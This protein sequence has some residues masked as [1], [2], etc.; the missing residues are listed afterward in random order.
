MCGGTSSS[1]TGGNSQK[2]PSGWGGTGWGSM[3]GMF[4]YSGKNPAQSLRDSNNAGIAN[5]SIQKTTAAPAASTTQTKTT[6][7]APTQQ[8]T[9]GSKTGAVA[10][11]SGARMTSV[12][13]PTGIDATQETEEAFG[14]GTIST[15]EGYGWDFAKGQPTGGIPSWSPNRQEGA[16]RDAAAKAIGQPYDRTV[17]PSRATDMLSKGKGTL[18]T[19]TEG[20]KKGNYQYDEEGTPAVDKLGMTIDVASPFAN[21]ARG[22]IL[23][24]FY[25]GVKAI[26]TLRDHNALKQAGVF[27]TPTTTKTATNT[28]TSTA[29]RTVPSR[30]SATGFNPVA[31]MMGG[32]D[33]NGRKLLVSRSTPAATTTVTESKRDTVA[34]RP[35]PPRG[36]SSLL[37]S[38]TQGVGG[39]PRTLIHLLFGTNK[40]EE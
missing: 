5:P 16:I 34:T 20:L 37:L 24:A 21:L 38:G 30:P 17:T 35:R 13:G 23:G 28:A 31:G 25:S 6:M 1:N 29:Q 36:R 32:D 14:G 40:Q 11:F 4:G 33:D 2:D 26:D 19:W 3:G 7:G 8:T 39:R 9:V 12:F 22:N 18:S 10:P 27:G 15:P